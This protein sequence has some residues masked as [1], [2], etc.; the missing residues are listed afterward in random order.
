MFI[1]VGVQNT[2]MQKLLKEGEFSEKEK[3]RSKIKG[4]VGAAYWC[5]LTAAYLILS[6]L[7]SRWDIT[8]LI[9]AVGGI[10]F[11]VVMSICNYISDKNNQK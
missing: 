10:L 7:T 8:W 5:L 2:S 11:P 4:A 6:F 9:F 1:V 3:T